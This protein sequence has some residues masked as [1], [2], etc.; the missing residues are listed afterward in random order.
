MPPSTTEEILLLRT[1][2]VGLLQTA[3]VAA[4]SQAEPASDAVVTWGRFIDRLIKAG[5][6]LRHWGPAL[7][8]RALVGAAGVGGHG[9]NYG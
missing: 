8:G 7:G 3:D 6:A 2:T 5:A 1:V 9:T 4:A